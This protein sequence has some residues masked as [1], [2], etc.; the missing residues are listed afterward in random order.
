MVWA[1]SDRR[2]RLPHNWP[3][4]RR[5]IIRRDGGRC[6]AIYTDGRRCAGTDVEVDHITPGDDHTDDNLRCLCKWHH[7]RKSATEGGT[8]AALKRVRT[9]RPTPTHPALED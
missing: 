6:T 5:R 2:A 8:A 7:A 1:G 4:I 3:T 9:A